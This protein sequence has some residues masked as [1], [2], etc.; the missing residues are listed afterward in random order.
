MIKRLDIVD[1]RKRKAKSCA[2][3]SYDT[4]TGEFGIRIAEHATV[5][6]VPMMMEPF[7]ARGQLDMGPKWSR[8][9]VEERVVPPGRQN[10]G[11]ILRAHGL[12]EYDA[13]AML[14]ASGGVSSQDYFV[15][16]LPEERGRSKR[17]ERRAGVGR[18]VAQARKKAG[19]R[20]HELAALAGVDQAVISRIECGKA[21]PTL[22]LLGS[23]ADALGADLVVELLVDGSSD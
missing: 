3:L 7:V 10:L 23:L 15:V 5:D 21:N 9:W 11:E 18:A 6:E 19:L 1:G 14:E 16:R 2:Q 13:Y 12:E 8:A 20:Q 4:E 22:D 17:D